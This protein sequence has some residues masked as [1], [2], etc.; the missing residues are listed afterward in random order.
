MNIKGFTL[1][2]LLITIGIISILSG[3]V[4]TSVS[5][6]DEVATANTRN[7]NTA[8]AIKTFSETYTLY[9]N[10]PADSLLTKFE[11]NAPH[12][13]ETGDRLAAANYINNVFKAYYVDKKGTKACHD[14][15]LNFFDDNAFEKTN[16]ETYGSKVSK[17]DNK[18][19]CL[20]YYR[21]GNTENSTS[22]TVIF[23]LSEDGDYWY[24]Q[25]YASN[26]GG[27]SDGFIF[28]T[29]DSANYIFSTC[30]TFSGFTLFDYKCSQ[31]N[32]PGTTGYCPEEYILD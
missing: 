18:V 22:T 25:Y 14:E 24:C 30:K 26:L 29:T 3:V 32:N 2:E 21:P 4:L 10:L 17:T 12:F 31:S 19:Y 27:F 1:I 20:K 15:N 5:N 6:K 23:R 7:F 11:E 9:G 16:A 8:Q 13:S 28:K